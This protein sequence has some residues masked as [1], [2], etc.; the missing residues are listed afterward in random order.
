VT[1]RQAPQQAGPFGAPPAPGAAQETEPN[2]DPA[3]AS[4][5]SPLGQGGTSQPNPDDQNSL[6]AGTP[7]DFLTFARAAHVLELTRYLGSGARVV[8]T[9]VPAPP[10]KPEG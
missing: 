3:G 1:V 9:T 10:K 4:D 6:S 7:P 8:R 5:A 2:A